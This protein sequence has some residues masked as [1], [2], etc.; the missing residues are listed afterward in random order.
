MVTY[1]VLCAGGAGISR[2]DDDEAVQ[3]VRGDH[4]GHEG[5]VCLLEHDRYDI[6]A[7]VSLSLQ[8]W[9]W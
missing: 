9:R 8:L 5:R 1:L 2:G 6:V 4:V 3:E 7:D